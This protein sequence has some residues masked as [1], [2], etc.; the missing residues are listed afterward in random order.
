M[1]Q[2]SMEKILSNKLRMAL[3][4][5]KTYSGKIATLDIMI[6]MLYEEE[7]SSLT[8]RGSESI[9]VNKA[10]ARWF[11]PVF[12]RIREDLRI[13]LANQEENVKL[14]IKDQDSK[15]LLVPAIDAG[16]LRGEYVTPDKSS[17]VPED[18]CPST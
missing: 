9:I 10:Q 4:A 8:M 2:D 11:V 18:R 6:Y 14:Y 5:C 16:D 3:E 7:V 1:S 17:P 13:K 15:P 12:E